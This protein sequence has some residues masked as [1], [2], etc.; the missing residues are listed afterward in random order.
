MALVEGGFLSPGDAL[1]CEDA[2]ICCTWRRGFAWRD[3]VSIATSGE[4]VVKALRSRRRRL[5]TSKH[6]S[7]AHANRSTSSAITMPA[8]APALRPPL[9]T[10]LLAEAAPDGE[11]PIALTANDGVP[12]LPTT[13]A[14]ALTP[15]APAAASKSARKEI[16]DAPLLA[17]PLPGR[18][19]LTEATTLET[20][21]M[22]SISSP[23]AV[24][25]AAGTTTLT[26]MPTTTYVPVTVLLVATTSAIRR[27][28]RGERCTDAPCESGVLQTQPVS[29][30]EAFVGQV[31]VRMF[32][33]AAAAT[34][35]K[36][37]SDLLT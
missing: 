23:A 30:L 15:M 18:I 8:I 9:P 7:I 14:D 27:A 16:L 19:A 31:A 20:S 35:K 11:P 36:V 22:E 10:E 3:C 29:C 13:T 24:S 34:G 1:A 21:A 33:E 26:V 5:A 17:L 28:T 2:D 37:L 12:A 32:T 4:V 25:D 6:R